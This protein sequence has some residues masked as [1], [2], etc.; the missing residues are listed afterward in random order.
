MRSCNTGVEVW[1]KLYIQRSLTIPLLAFTAVRQNHTT[2]LPVTSMTRWKVSHGAACGLTH[3]W[4][5]NVCWN[6]SL[7]CYIW[8]LLLITVMP[9]NLNLALLDRGIC[10]RNNMTLNDTWNSHFHEEQLWMVPWHLK[11]GKCH[12]LWGFLLVP[13]TYSSAQVSRSEGATIQATLHSKG[14]VTHHS[15]GMDLMKPVTY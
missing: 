14:S 11:C 15:R 4:R 7:K 12:H 6:H 1:T 9:F 13:H 10:I 2:P 8:Q 3:S 5:E